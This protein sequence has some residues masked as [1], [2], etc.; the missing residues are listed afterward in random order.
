MCSKKEADF[1][2]DAADRGALQSLRDSKLLL[3]VDDVVGWGIGNDQGNISVAYGEISVFIES[4][5]Y[6]PRGDLPSCI[7]S[8]REAPVSM[9]HQV[10]VR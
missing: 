4:D 5:C 2:A 7:M 9:Q 10:R 8:G 1:E 3:V 6:R